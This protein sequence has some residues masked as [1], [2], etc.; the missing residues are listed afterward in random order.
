M[1]DIYGQPEA[2]A[3]IERALIYGT[4]GILLTG[5]AGAP[6]DAIAHR[7]TSLLDPL[8]EAEAE[9]LGASERPTRVLSPGMTEDDVI[10]E[11][12]LS[13][14]GVVY[15]PQ[16]EEFPRSV[17]VVLRVSHETLEAEGRAPLLVASSYMCPCMTLDVSDHPLTCR[18]T[19]SEVVAYGHRI[20][21]IVVPLGILVMAPV[22]VS[23]S[24]PQGSQTSAAIRV[25]IS[26]ARGN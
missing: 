24:S 5:P 8:S 26:S 17:R 20:A 10:R 11:M 25:R 15:L 3:A 1:S 7:I 13:R 23:P 14:Y 16:I 6:K 21:Q 4:S 2:L 19:T 18:C 9:D 12:W 22:H